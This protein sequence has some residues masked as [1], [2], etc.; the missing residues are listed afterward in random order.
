MTAQKAGSKANKTANGTDSNNNTIYSKDEKKRRNTNNINANNQADGDT[1]DY[2]YH[3]ESARKSNIN[4]LNT[5][6]GG[7]QGMMGNNS[8][9]VS[10]N[11]GLGGYAKVESKSRL[12]MHNN[13]MLQLP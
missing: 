3:S 5:N 11:K 10:Q 12:K 9:N 4:N 13:K 8:S 7:L 6:D 1:E 2:N